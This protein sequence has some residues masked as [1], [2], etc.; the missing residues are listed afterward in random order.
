MSPYVHDTSKLVQFSEEKYR[1][2]NLYESHRMF[3]DIWC[4]LP[5]QGQRTH[6]HNDEDK[7]YYAI[8]GTCEVLVGD[9]TVPLPPG[10]AAT[11]PAGVMHGITNTSNEPATV[12]TFMGPHP[13]LRKD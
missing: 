8:S 5:G 4:L 1:K 3:C 7:V 6:V 12:L 13:K 2:I 11:I 9:E 10:H